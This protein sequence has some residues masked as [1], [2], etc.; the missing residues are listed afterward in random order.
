MGG[1]AMAVFFV[2]KKKDGSEL[3]WQESQAYLLQECQQLRYLE[4]FFKSRIYV[5]PQIV[6][7]LVGESN[8]V[9][10]PLIYPLV[11]TCPTFLPMGKKVGLQGY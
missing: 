3:C 9:L 1:V 11:E 7:N 10:T 6:G 4:F 8:T 2:G 5:V